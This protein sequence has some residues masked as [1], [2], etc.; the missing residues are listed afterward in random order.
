ML[1]CLVFDK[2]PIGEGW[3]EFYICS[4]LLPSAF[5][6]S[7]VDMKLLY[8]IMEYGSFF[9]RSNGTCYD[10]D[11]CFYQTLLVVRLLGGPKLVLCSYCIIWFVGVC[12]KRRVI[13]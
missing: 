12:V 2:D 1:C 8:Y 13:G 11:L 10:S 9:Y 5:K 3:E 7:F 6:F 4:D